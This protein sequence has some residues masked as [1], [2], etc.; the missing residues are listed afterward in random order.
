M[1][2]N[3]ILCISTHTSPTRG[4][5][6]PSVSI[7]NFLDFLSSKN[8]SYT[9]ITTS[10][11]KFELIKK[12]K[13]I[14]LFLPTLFF[15]KIGLSI[16]STFSIIFLS[17][18]KKTIIINGITTIPNFSALI[19]ALVNS[20][21]KVIIFSRGSFEVGRAKNWSFLKKLYYKLNLLIVKYLSIK[22]R[23]LII[24]QSKSEQEKSI[25]FSKCNYRI[26]GNIDESLFEKMQNKNSNYKNKKRINDLVFIGRYSPE[27]GI[28]RLIKIL[29]ILKQKKSKLKIVLIFDSLNNNQISDI[30]KVT[31]GL[32]Y[33]IFVNL[34]HEIVLD[35]L[36]KSKLIFFPSYIENYGNV[37]VESIIMG[38]IPVLY[39]NTQ[40]WKM[41][42]KYCYGEIDLI[43]F[44]NKGFI[45]YDEKL[46]FNCI[47]FIY[48]DCIKNNSF[49]SI[50]DFIF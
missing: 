18:F 9:L 49:N 32:N 43:N 27:K 5:G 16:T 12:D 1:T 17:I 4:F 31:N 42:P 29:K 11:F 38:S 8:I 28:D 44:I 39:E 26:I 20:R 25:S 15:H 14:E 7:R 6:G 40:W 34:D 35:K 13:V 30:K 24:F 3:D 45:Y 2:F 33:Q 41:Y 10:P 19:G 46:S 21:S 23:L 48:N 22:D 47:K 36:S 37:L 50:L